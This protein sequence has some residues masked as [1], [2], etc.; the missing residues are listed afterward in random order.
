[1]AALTEIRLARRRRSP[2]LLVIDAASGAGKSSFLRAGLWPRLKRDPGFAPLAVLRPAEGILSGPNGLGRQIGPY[3]ERFGAPRAAGEIYAPLLQEDEDK[4]A[5]SFAALV[6]DAAVHA[7][8]TGQATNRL[9]ETPSPVIAIDQAEELFQSG[10]D[11]ESRRFLSIIAS[12]LNAPPQGLDPYLLLTIRSDSVQSLLTCSAELHIETPKAIYLAPLSRAAY[13]EVIL[14]PAEIYN[15]RVKRLIV[16]PTLAQ[17]LVDDATGADALPLL[18]F[19]LE[20]LFADFKADGNLTL[21]RYRDIGGTGGSIAR[22]LRRAQQKAGSSGS[23]DKLRRLLLPRLATWDLEADEGRGAAKRLVAKY[24]NAAG[25]P[26]ADLAP[27]AKELVEARLLTHGHD[28]LEVAHEALL[29][30]PP[31]SKWV[32]EDREFLIWLANIARARQ[33]EEI[34]TGDLFFGG[35]LEDAKKWLSERREDIPPTDLEFIQNALRV[36]IKRREDE[37]R[38]REGE[39]AREL[40]L[41]R[42]REQKALERA[43]VATAE[44][45]RLKAN[46]AKTGF[47]PISFAWPP[48]SD[49]LRSPFRGLRPLEAEDAGIFFGREAEIIDA[50]DRLRSLSESQQPRLLVILGASGA[51]KSSFLRAGLWP[52]LKRDDRNY[53]PLPVIRPASAAISGDRG[54]VRSLQEAFNSV[55]APHT[56]ATVRKAV[57]GGAGVLSPLLEELAAKAAPPSIAGENSK[58]PML[59]FPVDQGEELFFTQGSDEAQAL[60]ALIRE[61]LFGTV[62]GCLALITIRSDAYERLQTAAALEGVLQHTLSL[63]PLA[64]GAYLDVIEGPLRRLAGTPRALSIEPALSQALL[65]DIDSGAGKDAL[66]LLAFTL[67]RLYVDYGAD[68]KLTLANYNALG[69]VKGSIEA[70][71]ERALKA[72]DLHPAVPRD[73]AAKLALLRRGLVPWLASIDP[74]TAAPR[75]RVARLS[76]IPFEARPLIDELVGA[77]LLSTDRNQVGESTI[78]PSNEAVLRQW[79]LLRS[80]LEQ[81]FGAENFG[82]REARG[83]RLAVKRESCFLAP[84]SRRTSIRG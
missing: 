60:L 37:L 63:R 17:R 84:A 81:D 8:R 75:R 16:E 57:E 73:R 32:A 44:L 26:R 5:A 31:I 70:A 67:E 38:R 45:E 18:A 76:E 14:K 30:Q 29:R 61:L 33:L 20:Q 80:W 25:G 58:A 78:E 77:R 42:M 48:E 1:M 43:G 7:S 51:G 34:N 69:R 4:A 53:F 15:A 54:L 27:L 28:T 62:P 68:G 9:S 66:P 47:A 39:V 55:G 23:D 79:G 65:S 22:A 6:T 72:S 36:E 82:G 46:L 3:F 49:P 10:D 2:R 71:V 41:T 56:R 83:W 12:L 19:S 40:E 52:R 13:R 11:S 59:V 35:P 24:E 74:D 21:D 64:K 50:L